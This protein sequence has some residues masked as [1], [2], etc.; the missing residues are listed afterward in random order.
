MDKDEWLTRMAAQFE[1][2]MKLP[3]ESALEALNVMRN[4]LAEEIRIIPESQI[5]EV[6]PE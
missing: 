2:A 3:A 5:S 6:N 4:E 1:L